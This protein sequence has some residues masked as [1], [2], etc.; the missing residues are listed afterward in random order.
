MPPRNWQYLKV[1]LN[2]KF[3]A[4]PL[5][6]APVEKKKYVGALL[7]VLITL[8]NSPATFPRS[9]EAQFNKFLIDCKANV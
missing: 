9:Y 3:N 2:F 4:I 1:V 8:Y 6:V 7:H 5:N